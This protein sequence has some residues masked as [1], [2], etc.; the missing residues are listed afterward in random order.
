MSQIEYR[1]FPKTVCSLLQ[2]TPSCCSR[3]RLRF[4]PWSTPAS[5]RMESSTC[6]CPAPPSRTNRWAA[7]LPLMSQK[8][9]YKTYWCGFGVRGFGLRMQDRTAG[10][11]SGQQDQWWLMTNFIFE[12][13]LHKNRRANNSGWMILMFSAE[14][15][16][17]LTPTHGGL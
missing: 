3:K 2:A 5:R 7:V 17:K 8:K 11:L 15:I 16:H 6:V 13:M 10:C 14:L 4:R 9:M 1:L 12:A